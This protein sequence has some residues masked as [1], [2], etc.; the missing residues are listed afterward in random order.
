MKKIVFSVVVVLLIASICYAVQASFSDLD[1]SHWAFDTIIQMYDLGLVK[2]Y[3]DN[4]FKPD[5]EVYK[6]L[7]NINKYN[8]DTDDYENRKDL[9]KDFTL[10]SKSYKHS[11]DD[12]NKAK[13]VLPNLKRRLNFYERHYG[14][15]S[16]LY[17]DLHCFNL[18]ASFRLREEYFELVGKYIKE[19]FGEDLGDGRL[20][21]KWY[22]VLEK[23][24]GDK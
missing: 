10:K 8:P 20:Y 19:N 9:D 1:K 14:V 7:D 3:E 23:A 22:N 6:K 11:I 5:K 21:Q 12:V 18:G 13:S 16:K 4:T 24:I 15:K 17:R 2:G